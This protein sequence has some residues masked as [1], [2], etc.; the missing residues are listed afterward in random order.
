MYVCMQCLLH[1]INNGDLAI[2]FCKW[3][4]WLKLLCIIKC[5]F[6]PQH[7][8]RKLL[9]CR[10]QKCDIVCFSVDQNNKICVRVTIYVP[11]FKHEHMH[12]LHEHLNVMLT[13]R[14]SCLHFFE[15][16]NGC[17]ESHA[18]LFVLCILIILY[19]ITTST[20]Y[21]LYIHISAWHGIHS[22]A[23]CNSHVPKL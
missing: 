22:S 18:L 13:H 7:L 6:V 3:A 10:C 9:I 8:Q 21:M 4:V 17:Q 15:S 1:I 2:L 14:I 5:K 20:A 23:S 12:L 19:F 16:L 11:H